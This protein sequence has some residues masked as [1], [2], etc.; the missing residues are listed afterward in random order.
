MQDILIHWLFLFSG[1]IYKEVQVIVPQLI[2]GKKLKDDI[3]TQ[4]LKLLHKI[5]EKSLKWY[6]E[7]QKL[8][9]AK[10]LKEAF[11]LLKLKLLQMI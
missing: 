4:R 2:I 6:K 1:K 5:L 11:I 3:L 9:I 7:R 8:I 10:K